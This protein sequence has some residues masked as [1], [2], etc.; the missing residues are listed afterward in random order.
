MTTKELRCLPTRKTTHLPSSPPPT[1][2]RFVDDDERG[3]RRRCGVRVLVLCVCPVAPSS[4]LESARYAANSSALRSPTLPPPILQG[5]T[6]PAPYTTTTTK[7]V[8][9]LL[10]LR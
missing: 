4:A 9:A 1:H 5:N 8:A 3:G 7:C 6:T 2:A 10:L